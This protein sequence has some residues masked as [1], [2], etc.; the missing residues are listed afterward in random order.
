LEASPKSV[1]PI[2]GSVEW[3][4]A[5]HRAYERVDRD[6]QRELAEVLP[7]AELDP[8]TAHRIGRPPRLA[9]TISA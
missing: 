7:Q 8:P 5:D 9:A 2:S 6:R 3:L 1:S 4:E